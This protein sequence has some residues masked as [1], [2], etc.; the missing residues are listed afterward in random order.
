MIRLLVAAAVCYVAFT[1]LG[2]WA[3]LLR[4]WG[5]V[6]SGIGH[7]CLADARYVCLADARL[8]YGRHS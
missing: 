5:A 4:G 7:V 1:A 2:E 8:I 3:V 6:Y